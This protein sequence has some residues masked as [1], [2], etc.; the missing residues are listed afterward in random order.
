MKRRRREAGSALIELAGSLILLATLLTGI[1]Q[2]GY[3]F[4]TYENLVQA[5]RAGARYAS[6]GARGSRND[7][8]LAAAVRNLVVYGDPHAGAGKP[9]APGLTT[10]QVQVILEPDSATVS[11]R[12]FVI[13]AVFA[14]VRLDGRPTV[15]FPVIAGAER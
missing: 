9:V 12:G 5:V 13:D 8:E 15:T 11:V 7:S 10:Q 3:T 1:F 6:L 14:K 4:Y 2:S